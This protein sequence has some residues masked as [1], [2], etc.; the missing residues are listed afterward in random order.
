MRPDNI[1]IL[2]VDDEPMLRR[3]VA[4]YLSDEGRF[5]VQTAADA[6]E[7]LELLA[8]RKVDL[9]L[10]DLRLPG[11]NGIDFMVRAQALDQGLR[12]LI[13]TGSPEELLPHSTIQEISGFRGVLFKPLKNMGDIVRAIDAALL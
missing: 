2:V 13:H 12:F 8:R 3:S 9:C 7:G 11:L 1:S 5:V 4:D 10:V 6:E